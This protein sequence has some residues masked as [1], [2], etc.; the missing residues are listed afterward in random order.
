MRLEDKVII[1]IIC[2]F[3]LLSC[4]AVTFAA[5]ERKYVTHPMSVACSDCNGNIVHRDDQT[6]CLCDSGH[7]YVWSEGFTE[8][9]NGG[10]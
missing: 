3:V 8:E 7:V 10:K 5:A 1:G 6:L 4:C 2:L 9:L